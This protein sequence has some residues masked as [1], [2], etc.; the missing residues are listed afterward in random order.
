VLRIRVSVRAGEDGVPR[1][2][3]FVRRG[4][5]GVLGPEAYRTRCESCVWGRAG[6]VL[7]I[8]DP[9]MCTEDRA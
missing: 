5:G 9:L 2:T 8:Q 7:R 3:G 1:N 6:S 4:Q